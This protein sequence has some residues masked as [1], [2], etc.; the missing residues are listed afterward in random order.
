MGIGEYKCTEEGIKK[1]QKAFE[2]DFNKKNPQ[3]KT[4]NKEALKK[5][6]N[7]RDTVAGGLASASCCL[8]IRNWTIKQVNK[9]D[10]KERPYILNITDDKG[11]E[12]ASTDQ[13]K[14]K[15]KTYNYN[16]NPAKPIFH[17]QHHLYVVLPE[18]EGQNVKIKVSYNLSHKGTKCTHKV[19]A[20]NLVK[21]EEK[22]LGDLGEHTSFFEIDNEGH[23]LD[24][25][26]LKQGDKQDK[27]SKL[28]RKIERLKKKMKFLEPYG[29]PGGYAAIQEFKGKYFKT[30]TFNTPNSKCFRDVA[31]EQYF[32]I[33]EQI[34]ILDDKLYIEEHYQEKYEEISEKIKKKRAYISTITSSYNYNKSAV[35]LSEMRVSKIEWEKASIGRYQPIQ[36]INDY[37]HM[38]QDGFREALRI[39]YNE[40]EQLFN[41]FNDLDYGRPDS[42]PSMIKRL[43]FQSP[44]L[45]NEIKVRPTGV[46]G[47][48]DIPLASVY[49]FIPIDV[50]GSAGFSLTFSSK[51][52]KSSIDTSAD[53]SIE[54][55]SGNKKYSY[56]YSREK[57]V[58]KH[59]GVSK[60]PGLVPNLIRNINKI[61]EFLPIGR[62]KVGFKFPFS[63]ELK[64]DGKSQENLKSYNLTMASEVK[65]EIRTKPEITISILSFLIKK[66]YFL[67]GGFI[68][69]P[70]LSIAEQRGNI[71]VNFFVKGDLGL[72]IE[73]NNGKFS[74]FETE[75]SDE[76][77]D[78]LLDIAEK[79][80]ISFGIK[81][82]AKAEI[83]I[84]NFIMEFKAKVGVKASASAKYKLAIKK[85]KGKTNKGE[86]K[87]KDYL[88]FSAT[89]SGL[90][91]TAM[92]YKENLSNAKT[93]GNDEDG[94]LKN[95]QKIH[96]VKGE[97]VLF[98]SDEPF[99]EKRFKLPELGSPDYGIQCS[100][101]EEVFDKLI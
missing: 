3:E 36:D 40:L 71:S 15:V 51:N 66:L 79:G 100:S 38:R 75:S 95:E 30:I 53:G 94:D 32:S 41:E 52:G 22:D 58:N 77:N 23:I 92:V 85:E 10:N 64:L 70:I 68:F 69:A 62:G 88:S 67:P 91:L 42:L 49:A 76:K 48:P 56:S 83:D 17:K 82:V 34:N 93:D 45:G 4:A 72:D 47:Y 18:E 6:D 19:I 50:S 2:E 80:S 8:K 74:K 44:S 21:N 26:K 33:E 63:I 98:K 37:N 90:V 12:V 84:D 55:S 65:I 99:F 61:S 78:D 35:F 28:K 87:S 29:K 31:R 54:I 5:L 24:S 13:E 46:D 7:K 96:S 43:I 11:K 25:K 27:I 81:G 86:D 59:K 97:C 9:I 16:T 73:F 39:G 20:D 14:L 89:F 57:E 101:L 1:I 60:K